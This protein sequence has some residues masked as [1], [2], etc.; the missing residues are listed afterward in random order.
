MLSGLSQVFQEI[1]VTKATRCDCEGIQGFG[2]AVRS[3]V[4]SGGETMSTAQATTESFLR[5]S[6]LLKKNM[7]FLARFA[8]LC[9]TDL[10][11]H[12]SDILEA[13]TVA[14]DADPDGPPLRELPE[15]HLLRQDVFDLGLDNT[16]EGPG[17]E[18]IV[19]SPLGEPV[20]CRR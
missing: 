12:L 14:V 13:Q 10:I 3:M 8:A 18:G 7:F 19:E 2:K 6:R 1:S 4:I 16:P 11:T 5:R 9:E 15:Q 17:A 20:L